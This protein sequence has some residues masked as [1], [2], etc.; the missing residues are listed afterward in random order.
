MILTVTVAGVGS[1]A[2]PNPLP[3][4]WE[5]I[6]GSA[7]DD[8]V[9]SRI[10][11]TAKVAQVFHDHPIFG[12]GI[13]AAPPIEFGFVDNQWLGMIVS[14]GL[15]GL[16]AMASLAIGGIF[17][18]NSSLRHAST[19]VERD[20]AYAIGGAFLGILAT[21]YTFDLFA[22]GQVTLI[23]FILF[24]LLWSSSRV[25]LSIPKTVVAGDDPSSPMTKHA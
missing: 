4:L 12:V 11:A 21:S 18:F 10:Q 24:G 13:G 22:F 8:S 1:L 17:G 25:E 20:Q 15:V 23:F 5:S 14:G 2:S 16:L 9:L 7:E 19:R 6:T 3:A